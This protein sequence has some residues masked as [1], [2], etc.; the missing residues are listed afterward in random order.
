VTFTPACI[1]CNLKL[2]EGEKRGDIT[3]CSVFASR[4]HRCLFSRSGLAE[5]DAR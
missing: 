5:N 2:S 4:F 1:G 3:G